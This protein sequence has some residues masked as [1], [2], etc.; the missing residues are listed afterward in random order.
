MEYVVTKTDGGHGFNRGEFVKIVQIISDDT[1]IAVNGEGKFWA[2]KRD[3]LVP[4]VKYKSTSNKYD[5]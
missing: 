2:M 5:R 1:V 4:Y 3:Q